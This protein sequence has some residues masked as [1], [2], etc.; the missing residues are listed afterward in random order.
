MIAYKKLYN[1]SNFE[2]SY[3][4]PPHGW[5]RVQAVG[6]CSIGLFHRPTRHG[7]CLDKYIDIDMVCCQPRILCEIARLNG[8]IL[9]QW[10]RYVRDPKR[11]RTVIARF[12]NVSVASAKTLLL[13]ICFGGEYAEWMRD[14]NIA[15]QDK[16]FDQVVAMEKEML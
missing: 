12:H 4:F 6:S 11:L 14:E 2:T 3:F 9:E 1:G 13:R 10:E 7:L 5:G 15:E 8:H 16:L